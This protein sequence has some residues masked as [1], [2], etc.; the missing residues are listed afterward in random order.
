MWGWQQVD[1]W[2]T[3]FKKSAKVVAAD[4]YHS[5]WAYTTSLSMYLLC[6]LQLMHLY[7]HPL[8]SSDRDSV[9]WK[10]DKVKVLSKDSKSGTVCY[11]FSGRRIRQKIALTILLAIIQQKRCILPVIYTP[12]INITTTINS[13]GR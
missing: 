13:T 4:V 12:I 8:A 1:A 11:R 3:W 5:Q 2:L 10:S 9:F 7:W 6:I